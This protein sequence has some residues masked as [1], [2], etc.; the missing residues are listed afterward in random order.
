MDTFGQLL[1]KRAARLLHEISRVCQRLADVSQEHS[2]TREAT[3]SP[4]SQG[5]HS[6]PSTTSTRSLTGHPS[7]EA[8]ARAVSGVVVVE[9]PIS[10]CS[11]RHREIPAKT[12]LTQRV[13]A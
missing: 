2:S 9:I 3:P 7:A 11:M 6:S 8:K 12:P 1:P 5:F 10:I 4:Q 13:E